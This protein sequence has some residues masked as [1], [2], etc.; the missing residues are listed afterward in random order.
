MLAFA[1]A[2]LALAAG[3]AGA[4]CYGIGAAQTCSDGLGHTYTTDQETRR[5]VPL[6]KPWIKTTPVQKVQL[7]ADTADTP[8]DRKELKAADKA[9]NF[10]G[11][12]PGFAASAKSPTTQ[13]R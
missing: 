2:G 3:P 7:P 10:V 6:N 1:T 11:M 9:L 8:T 12:Y 4:V 13:S 5:V